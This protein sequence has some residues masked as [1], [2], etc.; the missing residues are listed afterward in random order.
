MKGLSRLSG[1]TKHV[2]ARRRPIWSA[3]SV[4]GAESCYGVVLTTAHC[5]PFGGPPKLG[6]PPPNPS[7]HKPGAERKTTRTLR[8]AP[9]RPATPSDLRHG[10]AMGQPRSGWPIG[11]ASGE[12]VYLGFGFA[13]AFAARWM[14]IV[15]LLVVKLAV[16]AVTV[17]VS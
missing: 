5:P 8:L 13:V 9:R 15:W 2:P 14:W 10:T 16:V 11:G 4:S 17:T 1:T 7:R 3:L 12:G 6:H